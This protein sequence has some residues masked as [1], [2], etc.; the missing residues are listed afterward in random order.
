ME[1][2]RWQAVFI[3]SFVLLIVQL[4]D[5]VLFHEQAGEDVGETPV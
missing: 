5:C 2:S 1:V 4:G 3:V